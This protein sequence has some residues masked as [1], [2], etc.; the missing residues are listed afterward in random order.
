MLTAEDEKY[1]KGCEH[2]ER[3]YG[4]KTCCMYV[5]NMHELRPCKAGV[6]C[7]VRR[8]RKNKKYYPFQE[9]L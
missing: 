3:F 1:C 2:N 5:A 9:R 6:G 7:T 8:R 4:D